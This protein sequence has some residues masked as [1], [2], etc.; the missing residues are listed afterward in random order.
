MHL[1]VDV[2]QRARGGDAVLQRKA[3]A[4]RRLRAV[5]QHPPGAVRAAAELEGAEV[6][7]MSA[8]RLDADHRAQEFRARRD[9]LGRQQALPDQRVVAVDVGADRLEQVGAL[10]QPGADACPF[11]LVDEQRDMRQRPFALLGAGAVVDAVVDAGVAQILVGAGEALLQLVGAELLE[12]GDELRPDRPRIARRVDHF[13]ENAVERPIGLQQQ[14]AGR[15]CASA[16]VLRRF[17]CPCR[18]ITIWAAA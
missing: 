8:G 16:L 12:R 13:V 1:A 11:R 9:Q 17:P 10:H 15:P 5:A 3:G 7:E 4:R 18:A 14:A 6:Q 2:G